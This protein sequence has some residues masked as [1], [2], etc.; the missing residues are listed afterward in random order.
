M[1]KPCQIESQHS[2]T[3]LL[4]LYSVLQAYLWVLTTYPCWVHVIVC[5]NRSQMKTHWPSEFLRLASALSISTE[6]P[7][8]VGKR[9]A[10]SP[11]WAHTA[12]FIC[13]SSHGCFTL[14]M[15]ALLL[16]THLDVTPQFFS[17][18][19]AASQASPSW[20]ILALPSARHPNP[21]ARIWQASVL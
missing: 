4:N 2:L 6:T 1:A 21:S 12:T 9:V 19:L 10:V 3:Q 20:L 11:Q 18:P 7:G 15:P 5:Q 13:F 8:R 14:S 17:R 16:Y